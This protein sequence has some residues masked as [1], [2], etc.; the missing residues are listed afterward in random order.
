[1][2]FHNIIF[3]TLSSHYI[4]HTQ[5]E[6][7]IFF[8]IKALLLLFQTTLILQ[9]KSE[10]IRKIVVAL[11][12]KS[13]KAFSVLRS[14]SS[15]DFSVTH[16]EKKKHYSAHLTCGVESVHFTPTFNASWDFA[17]TSKPSKWEIIPQFLCR[18][19]IDVT[20]A[21]ATIQPRHHDSLPL[22]TI[23]KPILPP[24]PYHLCFKVQHEN[25]ST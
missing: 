21:T 11:H 6:T 19:C 15:S 16:T 3:F 10:S 17:H 14:L 7:P 1:M 24:P 12:R 13:G 20:V 8:W 25:R 4:T 2:C 23:Y 9:G 18:V 5:S 22:L